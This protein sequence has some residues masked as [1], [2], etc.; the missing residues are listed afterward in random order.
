MNF[1]SKSMGW[2]VNLVDKGN[3][4]K[5]KIL[6][7]IFFLEKNAFLSLKQVTDVWKMQPGEVNALYLE[8]SWSPIHIFYSF[9]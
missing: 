5:R 4:Q 7:I 8:S 3:K 2:K 6:F 1:Y 9:M